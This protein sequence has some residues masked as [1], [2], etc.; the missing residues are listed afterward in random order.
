MVS[1]NESSS[2]VVT[3]SASTS[4]GG[5]ET[6]LTSLEGD[7]ME[8]WEEYEA[9]DTVCELG[10]AGESRVDGEML[11][12]AVPILDTAPWDSDDDL[13][14]M[15][16]GRDNCFLDKVSDS[17]DFRFDAILSIQRNSHQ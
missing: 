14:R 10:K 7:V 5:L 2:S 8:T 9:N 17:C 3:A 1:F 6:T 15:K 11:C 16:A 13:C 12:S 4:K